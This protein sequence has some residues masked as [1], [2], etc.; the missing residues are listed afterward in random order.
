[1]KEQVDSY[2]TRGLM[3][4]GIL[5][6]TSSL[7]GCA[8]YYFLFGEA[9]AE[10]VME[11]EPQ[12]EPEPMPPPEPVEEIMVSDDIHVVMPGESLWRIS[13]LSSIYND[14]FRWP[15]IFAHNEE[16]EKADLI[17]PGQ[18]LAIRRDLSRDDINNAV[19][20][21]KNRGGKSY[22]DLINYDANYRNSTMMSQ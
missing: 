2:I 11:P 5:L 16:I 20:H 1:M 19:E 13:G 6:L 8:L 15:L 3:L 21:A 22:S 10:V 9:E 14:P 17:F 7:S 18:E 4:V 12:P